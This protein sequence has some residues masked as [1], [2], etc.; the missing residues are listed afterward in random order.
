M[1]SGGDVVDIFANCKWICFSFRFHCYYCC[2]YYY[3][4]V[5]VQ[6]RSVTRTH[7][8]TR[9]PLAPLS[10]A[11]IS[12]SRGPH[13]HT[14]AQACKQPHTHAC[15]V[16]LSMWACVCVRVSSWTEA[17]APFDLF[18]FNF[19]VNAIAK[20]LRFGCVTWRGILFEAKTTTTATK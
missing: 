5:A 3:Y 19:A 11:A 17:P 7:T 10:L 2:Y 9:V 4:F 16:C 13:A 8:S 1:S 14:H 6:L 12:T 15:T 18:W 20:N